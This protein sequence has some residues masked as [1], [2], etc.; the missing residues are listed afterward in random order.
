MI[1]RAIRAGAI[2]SL[3]A[4]ACASALA[5]GV[6]AV[7]VA[8]RGAP[9]AGRTSG[10]GLDSGD[11]ASHPGTG[12]VGIRV[13]TFGVGNIV[14][15]G[16]WAGIRL[17]VLDRADRPRDAAVRLH[18]LDGD[19]DTA[20]FTRFV[21]LNPGMERGVWL[22]AR[23]P[24]D[25]AAGS[26]LRVSVAEAGARES[27]EMQPGRQIAWRPIRPARVVSA[28]DALAL[29]VGTSPMGLDQYTMSLRNRP[30]PPASHE[31]LHPALGVEPSQLPDSWAGLA[32]FEVIVWGNADPGEMMPDLPPRAL[33]EW[34]HRGGHLVIVLPAVGNPWQSQTNPLA[35]LLP[36]CRVDRMPDVDL[37]PYR[38]LMSGGRA[39]GGEVRAPLHKFNIDRDTPAADASPIITGPHGCV[40]VRRLVG[41]GMVTMIGL[42][43]TN[44]RLAQAGWMRA[45]SFWSRILG[46]RGGTPS[47]GEVDALEQAG[48]LGRA[49]PPVVWVDE[50]IATLISKGREAGVGV[51]LGLIVFGVYWIIA[52]PVGFALLRAKGLER[53]AWVAFV[54]VAALFTVVAWAGAQAL[55]PKIEQGWHVTLLDHVYGQPVQRAR[56]FVSVLL[57]RYGEQQVS[58]GEPGA[59]AN[60]SQMLTPWTDPTATIRPSFPDARA[61]LADAR[62]MTDLVVP[63][64]STIKTF[65]G[66]WLGGPRWS[67]PVPASPEQA[68]RI[69]ATGRLSGVLKHNLPRP[70]AR[71]H[72]I[73]VAGQI[74]EQT[75][76]R[77]D[78]APPPLIARAF[79]W[80]L[81][82]PWLP[83]TALDLS[84][85]QQDARADASKRLKSLVPMLGALDRAL[86]ASVKDEDL[87]DMTALYSVL[88]PPDME[89]AAGGVRVAAQPRR[90]LT[91]GFD[92]AR[93]FTQPCLIIIGRVDDAPNPVPM[94]VDGRALDGR[95]RPSTGRTVVRWVYPLPPRP[96]VV[97]GG[98]GA[99]AES[100]RSQGE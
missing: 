87:D 64:R 20:V 89:R 4:L 58:L 44:R 63:A 2:V 46:R 15:P 99:T 96:V 21:S 66:D 50:R 17:A 43:L 47:R 1:E 55:R 49:A 14:R 97:G 100:S 78:T 57:P 72:L 98:P 77:A 34:V 61:Y 53:H 24:W 73:I 82:D 3:A 70:L 41:T 84:L 52:G 79:D 35:D 60:W 33:R 86:P 81:P 36:V 13:E 25:L 29:V 76:P 32:P 54:A 83:G 48:T 19:G 11:A 16:D 8:G 38:R 91:H 65:Q 42:D 69:D 9:Q 18:L 30:Q 7:E 39:S 51:I 80:A 22:Y 59:D 28:E 26:V 40:V 88:E 37:S 95:D 31:F 90:R 94:Y 56:T 74:P 27:G 5:G 75:T 45:D 71:G 68:P 12:E 23:L 92:L 93:W 67:M 85:F 10:D 6:R 62:R